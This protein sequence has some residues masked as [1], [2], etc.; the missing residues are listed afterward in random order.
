[1]PKSD[2]MML[3]MKTKSSGDTN[4]QFDEFHAGLLN[5][6]D[7]HCPIRTYTVKRN[8]FRREPWLTPG[9]LISC[10]KQKKLYQNSIS[11]NSKPQLVEKYKNYW[12]TLKR[13]KRVSRI[14]FSKINV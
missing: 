10:N 9:L 5:C 6:L 3:Q 14:N 11:A 4:E 1:M 8:K 12:N 13:L 7:T 2:L